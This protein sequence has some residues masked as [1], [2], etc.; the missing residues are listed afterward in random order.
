MEI[1]QPFFKSSF[2]ARL[3][4]IDFTVIIPLVVPPFSKEPIF[5][6]RYSS[7]AIGINRPSS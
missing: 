7:A 2:A 6:L 1:P 4:L 5:S 3:A